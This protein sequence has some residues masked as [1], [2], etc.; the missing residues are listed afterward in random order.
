VTQDDLVE[1]AKMMHLDDN[2]QEKFVRILRL[3]Y[4]P[5]SSR[6]LIY[7]PPATGK[8]TF[9]KKMN[10]TGRSV[11]ETDHI[12]DVVGTKYFGNE[13]RDIMRKMN[14]ENKLKWEMTKEAMEYEIMWRLPWA[15]YPSDTR[16]VVTNYHNIINW[17]RVVGF[18]V[19]VVQITDEEW[20]EHLKSRKDLIENFGMDQLKE[21]KRDW[22]MKI[23]N[24]LGDI[25]LKSFK[26]V[27][28]IQNMRIEAAYKE[29]SSDLET[30]KGSSD[31]DR[32]QMG[33]VLRASVMFGAEKDEAGLVMIGSEVESIVMAGDMGINARHTNLA[34]GKFEYKGSDGVI[35]KPDI[36]TIRDC[37]YAMKAHGLSNIYDANGYI[38]SIEKIKLGMIL[39]DASTA[40]VL[41]GSFGSI[42]DKWIAL[43]PISLKGSNV[44][45]NE[46]V[47]WFPLPKCKKWA[48]VTNC[49]NTELNRVRVLRWRDIRVALKSY[50]GND[51]NHR[52][53][54]EIGL[55]TKMKWYEMGDENTWYTALFS[56]SN[57]K[58]G[59]E[60]EVLRLKQKAKYIYTF[61]HAGVASIWPGPERIENGKWVS[62]S[63]IDRLEWPD[64]TG[65]N[66]TVNTFIYAMM[67]EDGRKLR[68]GYDPS[69]KYTQIWGVNT[70]VIKT[71]GDQD[72]INSQT[73]V[74][75]FLTEGIRQ[76][77]RHNNST[78]HAVRRYIII[79]LGGI[80]IDSERVNGYVDGEFIAIAGHLIN[81]LIAANFGV[82]DFDR[83]LDTIRTNV[84]RK[85]KRIGFE[86]FDANEVWHSKIE[87]LLSGMTY[88]LIAAVMKLNPFKEEVTHINNAISA[89][90]KGKEHLKGYSAMS[91]ASSPEGVNF[92]RRL[93]SQ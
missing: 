53:I 67:G 36:E 83:W 4:F 35:E 34:N 87:W 91:F 72:L 92:L 23:R 15:C 13:Y 43:V 38:R 58:A 55:E 42:A 14:K 57:D 82:I 24:G 29:R 75:K 6:L 1:V 47:S 71:G 86:E 41:V 60:A 78:L 11:I 88:Q 80:P 74:V 52:A 16:Y 48:G 10:S 81:L 33:N 8:T 7:A 70:S 68:Y 30:I 44:K 46:D 63:Y 64:L 77:L 59:N 61:I 62:E 27:E 90:Y 21:W 20:N 37:C 49:Y 65:N 56:L 89:I 50:F 28:Q 51:S 26:D 18:Q 76:T 32:K 73:H 85:K 93:G 45:F 12:E 39:T 19:V 54:I 66:F 22:E 40:N 31:D 5:D 2:W 9:A 25:V 17:G 84:Y 79:M 69:S 3:M